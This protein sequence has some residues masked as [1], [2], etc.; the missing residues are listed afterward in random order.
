M[1]KKDERVICML[2]KQM[3]KKSERVIG[4]QDKYFDTSKVDLGDVC[5]I[6]E[7]LRRLKEYHIKGVFETC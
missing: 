2:I 4:I 7:I 6:N 3:G 5:D 1:L